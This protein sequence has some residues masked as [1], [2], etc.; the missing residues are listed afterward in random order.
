M[1]MIP[2][3]S[4][5]WESLDSWDAPRFAALLTDHVSPA[6]GW[7]AEDPVFQDLI[8]SRDLESPIGGATDLSL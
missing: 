2:R 7:E 6:K 1:I 3:P 8:K 4:L 5:R